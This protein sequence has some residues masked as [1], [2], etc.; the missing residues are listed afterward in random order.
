MDTKNEIMLSIV[1]LCYNHEPYL[2]QALDSIF[3]QKVNFSYEVL[4]GDDASSDHSQEI[5]KEYKRKYPD[6]VRLFLR[7]KNVGATRSGYYLGTQSRGKYFTTLES[8]DYWSDENKLQKQ[9]DFLEANPDFYACTHA[10]TV[11]DENNEPIPSKNDKKDNYFWYFGKEIYTLKDFEEGKYSG[12]TST[13]VS[14]N[15]YLDKDMDCTIIYKGHRTIGDRSMQLLLAIQGKTYVM[16][17][18][19]SCYRLVEKKDAG[20]WQAQARAKNRRHEEFAYICFLER[21]ARKKMGIPIDLI[22]VKKDKMVCAAV[23][24]LNQWNMENLKV[25]CSMIKVSGCPAKMTAL[26][27]RAILQKLFYRKILKEDRPIRIS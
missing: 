23:V 27:I 14:R 10:C 1:V 5:M 17:E 26:T 21:Y 13:L 6:K 20:N 2:R 22:A 4:L 7:K 25:V 15:P 16:S 8:D 18:S 3:S 19:M 24:F 9:I 12:H 11:V